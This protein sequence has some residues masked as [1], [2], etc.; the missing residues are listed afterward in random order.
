MSRY[1]IL[2]LAV[3]EITEDEVGI[4]EKGLDSAIKKEKGE[5]ISFEKWG[6]CRL[7]YPVKHNDYGIYFLTRFEAESKSAV[8]AEIKSLFTIKFNDTIMRHTVCVVDP[9]KG[10][11]YRR[12]ES[13][14]E[15]PTRDV[16]SF[17]RENKME[18][19]ISKKSDDKAPVKEVAPVQETTEA[20]KAE[21]ANEEAAPVKE[22]VSTEDKGE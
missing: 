2:M 1:E 20:P 21:A 6:R 19:L 9:K 3:P 12:P 7:A 13:V 14:D 16:D 22:D 4:I 18:G 15:I 17:L 10:L 8:F 5:T 11:E